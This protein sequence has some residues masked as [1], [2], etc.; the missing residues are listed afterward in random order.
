MMPRHTKG[1][2]DDA[3]WYCP[4]PNFK[5]VSL[6]K[7][8]APHDVQKRL[9]RTHCTHFLPVGAVSELQLCKRGSRMLTSF[10]MLVQSPL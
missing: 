9:P 5:M 6:G 7:E 4:F 10:A 1:I 3:N 2:V 8:V